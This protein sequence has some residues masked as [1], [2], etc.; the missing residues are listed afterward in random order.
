MF[1]GRGFKSSFHNIPDPFLPLHHKQLRHRNPPFPETPTSTS[2][3]P[4]VELTGPI[5]RTNL[6]LTTAGMQAGTLQL[7]PEP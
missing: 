1:T 4:V 3:L 6:K 2:S 7:T 5:L